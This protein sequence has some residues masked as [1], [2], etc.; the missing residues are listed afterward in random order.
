MQTAKARWKHAY[1]H[2]RAIANEQKTGKVQAVIGGQSVT[3]FSIYYQTPHRL[4]GLETD[5]ARRA[6]HI[7]AASSASR[8][9]L[10]GWWSSHQSLVWAKQRAR[11]SLEMARD[12]RPALLGSDLLEAA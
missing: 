9:P 5:A 12:N 6:K 10:A 4:A 3:V 8:L 7:D 1:G 2:L 11:A